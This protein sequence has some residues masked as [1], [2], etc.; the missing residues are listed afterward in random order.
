MHLPFLWTIHVVQPPK[1]T[2]GLRLAADRGEDTAA[3][4]G[5]EEED[6]AALGLPAA[7]FLCGGAAAELASEMGRLDALRR[8]VAVAVASDAAGA[9][10][11]LASSNS[12]AGGRATPLPRC[13]DLRGTTALV[14]LLEERRAGADDGA[15]A[16]GTGDETSSLGVG[17]CKRVLRRRPMCGAKL[18]SSTMCSQWLM[19]RSSSIVKYRPTIAPRE[20]THGARSVYCPTRDFVFPSCCTTRVR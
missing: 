5:E 20:L 12:G 19:V 4:E 1:L 8:A 15:A 9:G 6:A 2:R 16:V 17:C 10:E 11:P 7:R 13:V 3:E 14:P 18:F